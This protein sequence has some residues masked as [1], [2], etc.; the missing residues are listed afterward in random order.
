RGAGP[1]QGVG[2][3]RIRGLRVLA[4]AAPLTDAA[5]MSPSLLG[6]VGTIEWCRATN[7]VLGRGER[8]RF[9]AAAALATSRALPHVLAARAGRHGSGPDPSALTPPDTAFTRDVLDACAE[10]D[11]MLVEHGYRSYV[12][13][14]ALGVA[15]GLSVDDEALFAAT[16]LHDHAFG[17]M[18]EISDK[19]FTLVGAE[20]AAE[21]LADSPLSDALRHDVLDAITLHFNP[22]V[23]VER[24]ALQH[25][26][27]DGIVLD[28]LGL[29]ALE[30]DHDGVRRVQERHPR[31]GFLLRGEPLL[32]AHRRRVPGCRVDA[33]FACG[34]GPALRLSPWRSAERRAAPPVAT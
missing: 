33:M 34:F 28:V 8:A 19:C 32:R 3:V 14:R 18:D 24:G 23:G 22:A 9:M 13:A 5:P 6:D 31:H 11:P 21:V 29:R 4:V 17:R 10:L 30:L 15:E 1:E 20:A 26:V 27:H 25:L 12:F 7:G 2:R 16:L